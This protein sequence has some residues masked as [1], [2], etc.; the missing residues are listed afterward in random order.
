MN[1]GKRSKIP[2]NRS[3]RDFTKK[4]APKP[5]IE[6]KLL[7]QNPNPMRGGIRL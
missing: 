5:N 1:P 6:K 3:K 2:Q 4:A 7:A